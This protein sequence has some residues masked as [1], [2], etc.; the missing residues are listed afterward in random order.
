ME[1]RQKLV[2]PALSPE[3]IPSRKDPFTCCSLHTCSHVCRGSSWKRLVVSQRRKQQ[4]SVILVILFEKLSTAWK[5]FL[6]KPLQ[7]RLNFVQQP[8]HALF[9]ESNLWAV[10]LDYFSNPLLVT[11]EYMEMLYFSQFT[12]I[13]WSRRWR[14]EEK[15]LSFCFAVWYSVYGKCKVTWV[16]RQC[17]LGRF[18]CR[19]CVPETGACSPARGWRPSLP[20]R[21]HRHALWLPQSYQRI[22]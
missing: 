14:R 7:T 11:A 13:F 8:N 21:H 10:H 9:L 5:T 2:L 1:E 4:E 6:R 3:W 19:L 18:F 17:R 12:L 20:G 16:R 15:V 22:L